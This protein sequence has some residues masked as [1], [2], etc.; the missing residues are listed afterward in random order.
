MEHGTVQSTQG[1]HRYFGAC[2][3]S[4]PGHICIQRCRIIYEAESA[5]QMVRNLVLA[6]FPFYCRCALLSWVS[7][8]GK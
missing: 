4:F 8:L 6:S 3:D 2:W 1:A 7:C 5:C